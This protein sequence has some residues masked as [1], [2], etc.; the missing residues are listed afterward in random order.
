MWRAKR[1]E[2]CAFSTS[3]RA[4]PQRLLDFSDSFKSGVLGSW[5]PES[6]RAPVHYPRRPDR[7][8][9]ALSPGPVPAADPY[10]VVVVHKDLRGRIEAR[11]GKCRFPQFEEGYRK[12]SSV[13]KNS[14]A[15][16]SASGSGAENDAFV[17]F[18]PWFGPLL[19]RRPG[20]HQLF[21]QLDRF[22]Y[23]DLGSA[24][25]CLSPSCRVG[26]SVLKTVKYLHTCICLYRSLVS[27]VALSGREAP[28]SGRDE[29]SGW[30]R[31]RGH[32]C[33]RRTR[34]PAGSDTTARWCRGSTTWARPLRPGLTQAQIE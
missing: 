12:R 11:P 33:S 27:V 4:T 1:A 10:H 6:C 32:H 25:A 7:G 24:S 17:V 3:R 16:F 29:E 14:L 20:R 18:W 22:R 28:R 19:D 8:N 13:L 31:R 2:K 26:V 34:A 21:Q 30:P 9:A 5:C 23:S 15:L